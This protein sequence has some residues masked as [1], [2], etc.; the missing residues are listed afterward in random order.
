MTYEQPQSEEKSFYN[1][2]E[3]YSFYSDQEFFPVCQ[4]QS[5]SKLIDINADFVT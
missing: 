2:E 3:D 5:I 1:H 4:Q